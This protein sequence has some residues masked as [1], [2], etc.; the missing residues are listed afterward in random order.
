MIADNLIY[1]ALGA[2][3]LM[4][5]GLALTVIEFRYGKP[6]QQA[7]IAEKHPEKVADFRVSTEGRPAR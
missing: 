5:I 7:E 6:R 3:V 4:L 2:F 1:F